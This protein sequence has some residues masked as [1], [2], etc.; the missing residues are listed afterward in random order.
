MATDEDP[1]KAFFVGLGIMFILFG[2]SAVVAVIYK[3]PVA[4]T[5][6]DYFGWIGGLA[7]AAVGLLWAA[8]IVWGIMLFFRYFPRPSKYGDRWDR[9]EAL[10]ILRERYARG[11]ITQEQFQQMTQELKRT[12]EERNG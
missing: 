8:F 11:E 2:V 9:D 12:R 7:G 5:A 3:Y 1:R 4:A 10:E 6:P